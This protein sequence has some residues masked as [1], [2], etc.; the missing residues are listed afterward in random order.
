MEQLAK[1]H[2][3]RCIAVE[4]LGAHVPLEWECADGHRWMAKPT[5]IKSG[6]WCPKCRNEKLSEKFRRTDALSLFRD[7]AASRGGKVLTTTAPRNDNQLIEWQCARGHKW[8]AKPNNILN[9]KWCPECSVGVGERICRLYFEQLFGQPFPCT[10]P[11]WLIIGGTRRELDGFCDQLGLAFEHQGQQH[12]R[13]VARFRVDD[14]SLERGKRVDEAK[15]NLC[16]K[17]GVTLIQ[18]PEIPTL[19]PLPAVKSAIKEACLRHGVRLPRDFD[20]KS[21]DLKS[22]W[23][24]DLMERLSDAAR[25]RGGKCLGHEFIGIAS[26]YRWEC[27]N[28]HQWEASGGNILHRRSWCPT[29]HHE[30]LRARR[31]QGLYK[32]TG[33][34]APVQKSNE[35]ES[36]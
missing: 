10:W 34:M 16:R 2:S 30:K 8:R 22:A 15:I 28:G 26:K 6:R 11:E 17:H 25:Q 21:I 29:C 20:R 24:Y 3:G 5:N 7:V 36:S 1:K 32:P 23:D 27:A 18:I 9:G 12:F 33:R 35:F 4:Y 31:A 19:T 14:A 13:K